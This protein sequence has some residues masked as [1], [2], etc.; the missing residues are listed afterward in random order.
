[1]QTDE[2]ELQAKRI[3]T[4][5]RLSRLIAEDGYTLFAQ[6]LVARGRNIVTALRSENKIPAPVLD[7]FLKGLLDSNECICTRCLDVG[8][9]ERAAVEKLL[10]N[11]PDQEF[12]NAVGSL[13]HAIGL[14][15]GVSTKTWEQLQSLNRERLELNTQIRRVEEELEEIHQK[16]GAKNDNQV[17][18]LEEARRNHLLKRD[19]LQKEL[20]RLGEKEEALKARAAEIKKAVDAIVESEEQARLA[21][22]LNQMDISKADREALFKALHGGDG[23]RSLLADDL[24]SDENRRRLS[25]RAIDECAK[26]MT[27]YDCEAQECHG[28]NSRPRFGTVVFAAWSG[29]RTT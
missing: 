6:G 24:Q 1:L 14:I 18:E 8:T 19:T 25:A 20:G 17:Q 10:S 3:E 16:L 22:L 27:R 29:T 7:T 13:D 2:R 12:N 21:K 15:D 4:T 23:L 11:A 28:H 26:K 9:S 5:R